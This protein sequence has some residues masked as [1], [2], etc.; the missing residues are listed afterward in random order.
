MVN[1]V[2]LFIGVS[3]GVVAVSIVILL[4]ARRFQGQQPPNRPRVALQLRPI[5]RTD[6]SYNPFSKDELQLLHTVTISQIDVDAFNCEEKPL[7]D[8]E[9]LRYASPDCS[10][11]LLTYEVDDAARVLS[12][13]HVYH[14]DCI[15]HW[16]IQRSARCPICKV[17][18]RK[19]LGLENRSGSQNQAT[20]D[21]AASLADEPHRHHVI[22]VPSPEPAYLPPTLENGR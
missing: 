20:Q 11:C 8:K 16:L 22:N 13:G 14:V 4:V 7:G 3:A 10:I 6:K 9:L 17:D 2:S 12:C 21:S 1:E 5:N 19:A 15:D 18:I